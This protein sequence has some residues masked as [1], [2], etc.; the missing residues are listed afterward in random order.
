MML[1]AAS[2]RAQGT[3][4]VPGGLLAGVTIDI[5]FSD[6]Q[7]A[8]ETITVEIECFLWPFNLTE[9]VDITLDETGHGTAPW[10]VLL[11]FGARFT[12]AGAAAVERDIT[13]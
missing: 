8:G 9:K 12:T 5:G 10:T 11:A 3:L 4:T 7:R 13:P 2:A 1:F 6:P